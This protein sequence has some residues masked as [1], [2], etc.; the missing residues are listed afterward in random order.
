MFH[1]TGHLEAVHIKT[2]LVGTRF[3]LCRDKMIKQHR[4]QLYPELT[5]VSGSEMLRPTSSNTS[6]AGM[7]KPYSD[8]YTQNHLQ[9]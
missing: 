3:L 6:L 7:T 1:K 8:M 4:S 9:T 2:C 5:K